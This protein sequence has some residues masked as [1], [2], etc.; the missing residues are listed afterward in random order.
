[1]H[2]DDQQQYA[3][4]TEP[5]YILGWVYDIEN[6]QVIDIG[7]SVGPPRKVVPA[8]PFPELA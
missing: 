3:T 1:M 6:G 2:L 7:V 8:S 5:V 4:N